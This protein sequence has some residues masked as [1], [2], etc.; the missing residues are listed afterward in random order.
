MPAVVC[1]EQLCHQKCSEFFIAGCSASFRGMA[2]GFDVILPCS[3]ASL[4]DD[5]KQEN[6]GGAGSGCDQ[7]DLQMNSDLFFYKMSLFSSH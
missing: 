4:L 2:V 7:R 1:V 5:K 6:L 3:S